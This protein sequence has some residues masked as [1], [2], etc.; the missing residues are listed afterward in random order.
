[1][2]AA[3]VAALVVGFLRTSVGGGIGLVLTPTLS[4]VLP[5]SVVLA[6]IAPLMNLSDPLALRYYWRPWDRRQLV[7]LRSRIAPSVHPFTVGAQGEAIVL[8]PAPHAA[9]SRI[10]LA[11]ISSSGPGFP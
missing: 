4:L 1:M 6:M 10:L 7:L 2:G 11:R 9:H 5:P 8:V 3:C